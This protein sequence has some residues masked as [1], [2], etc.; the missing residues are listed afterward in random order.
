MKAPVL[1][2]AFVLLLILAPLASATESLV[3]NGSGVRTKPI[4]GV[5]Y[6]LDLRVPP[7]LQRAAAKALIEAD[8]PMA[9][10]LT[11]RSGLINRKRYV[12]ATTEGFA[13]A[14][15]S[16]YVTERQQAFLSQFDTTVFRK[17]DIIVMSYRP[18]GLASTYRK[19]VTPG[20]FEDT[21]LG[22][23]PGLDLKKAVFAIWL[24]DSPVQESLK[25]G[26]LGGK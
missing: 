12:E 8:Q 7:A 25:T 22:T 3:P 18:G 24:G 13:Q 10:V 19:Q 20:V 1:L 9:F 15:K 5:M 26:L 16:G 21:L 17:G 11:I 6:E 23:L 2:P 4:L 14:A